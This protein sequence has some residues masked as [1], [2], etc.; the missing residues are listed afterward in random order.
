M[1]PR[2]G[3]P[4]PICGSPIEPYGQIASLVW[5]SRLPQFP[6]STDVELRV[7]KPALGNPTPF[8]GQD[9]LTVEAEGGT[10]SLGDRMED[11]LET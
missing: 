11:V 7:R 6:C 4:L 9:D 5:L 8:Q 1:G 10:A 3:S 2:E